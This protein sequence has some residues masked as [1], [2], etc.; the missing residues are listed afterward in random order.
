MPYTDSM[1]Y[2]MTELVDC[3]EILYEILEDLEDIRIALE[4]GRD[5][6]FFLFP[7]LG[8]DAFKTIGK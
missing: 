7:N 8:F 2:L 6:D 4:R 3:L 1:P 5:P